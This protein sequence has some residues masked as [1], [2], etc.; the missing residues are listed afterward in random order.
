M[1][2]ATLIVMVALVEYMYFTMRVGGMRGKTN[3]A[4]PAC[5]GNEAFERAFRV[6]QNTLEQLII[7]IPGTYAFSY[8]VSGTWVLLPAAMFII[9]RWLYSLE[10]IK[11]PKTRVPGMALTLL[12]NAVL[13]IGV[14]GKLIMGMI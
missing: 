9:G 4:P 5:T 6:Q 7:F 13:V 12:A 1:E 2:T 3:M 8:Y 10:Y 11:D 14:M